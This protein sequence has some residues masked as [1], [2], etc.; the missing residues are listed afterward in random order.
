MGQTRSRYQPGDKIGGRYEVYK[1]LIG[2]MGEV[3][4]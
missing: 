2:G 1:V 3:Y 4:F